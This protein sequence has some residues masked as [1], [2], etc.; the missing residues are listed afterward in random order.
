MI[1]NSSSPGLWPDFHQTFLGTFVLPETYYG[2]TV[3]VLYCVVCVYYVCTMCILGL[4][5]HGMAEVSVAV[6]LAWSCM[7]IVLIVQDSCHA[8]DPGSLA[9][10]Q[11][12]RDVWASWHRCLSGLRHCLLLKADSSQHKMQLPNNINASCWRWTRSICMAP[13]CRC[14]CKQQHLLYMG[15]LS[16]V[17]KHISNQWFI[18]LY[19]VTTWSKTIESW[20]KVAQPLLASEQAAYSTIPFAKARRCIWASTSDQKRNCINIH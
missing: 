5:I 2:Y 16:P 9:T 18:S 20:R 15:G 10:S 13:I 19:K 11:F 4:Y 1:C 12:T 8:V 3:S 14:S 7:S 6:W 17:E